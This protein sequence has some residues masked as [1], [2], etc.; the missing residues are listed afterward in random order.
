M[1]HLHISLS[2]LIEEYRENREKERGVAGLD[3]DVRDSEGGSK[4]CLAT[5]VRGKGRNV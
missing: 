5:K 4:Q 1:V 2:T 3:R